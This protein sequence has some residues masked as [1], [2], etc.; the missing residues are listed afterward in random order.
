MKNYLYILSLIVSLSLISCQRRGDG[1]FSSSDSNSPS[2]SSVSTPPPFM[3]GGKGGGSTPIKNQGHLQACWI[4]AYLA[5]IETERIEHYGDS[6]NLSPLWLVNSLMHE[7]AEAQYLT[8]GRSKITARGIGPDAERLIKEYGMVPYSFFHAS[9][10]LNSNMMERNITMKVKIAVN[11]RKGLSALHDDVSTALP[12][13]PHNLEKGFYLYGMHYTPKQFGESLLAGTNMQWLTSYTH[14][15]FYEPF[16]IELPDNH[17]HHCIMNVPI[18]SLYRCVINALEHRHSV[19]WEGKMPNEIATIAQTSSRQVSCASQPSAMNDAASLQQAR[20]RA[21]ERF[22]VTDDHA[23]AIIGITKDKQGKPLF[24]C[25]NSW[26]KEWGD[27]GFCYM[28]A[29]DF[30]VNTILVGVM[31]NS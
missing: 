29:E 1:I 10:D 24:I 19:F 7:Q 9:D 6:L 27:H 8:K 2:P 4:Y 3:G 23:M 31:N 30:L 13:I 15:P 17:H 18:D 21:F 5:C 20:Q 14:H 12:R 25:K 16:D 22:Q 11:A 26:G 28:K